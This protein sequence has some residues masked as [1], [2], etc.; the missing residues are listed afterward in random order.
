MNQAA[1]KKLF[2]EEH[3]SYSAIGKYKMCPRSYKFRYVDRAPPETRASA[4]VF[5]SA[6][7]EALAHFYTALKDNQ[8]EPSLEEI[9]KVFRDYFE[10]ELCKKTPVLFTEKESPEGLIETGTEML[11][12]FLEEA[13]RPHRVVAVESPFS[14]ELIDPETGE[15]LSP[16]LVGVFDCVV[17]D[18]D[19]RHRILEHKTAGK[20]WAQ[21]RVEN[22]MQITAY[23][24]VAPLVGYGNADVTIQVLLKTKKPDFV[25]YHPQRT[26]ADRDDFI[27]TAVGVLRAVEAEAFYPNRD[28]QCKSCSWAARCVA[29]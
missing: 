11:R 2:A 5:G 16:R 6:I 20:R 21:S 8:P 3:V 13:E 15:V 10:V 29:G 27:E 12:V 7:H 17:L 26:D 19:G 4:L 9:T 1:I 28:W 23:T 18:A 24:H 14:I 25:V 22:D